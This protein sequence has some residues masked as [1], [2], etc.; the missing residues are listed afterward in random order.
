MDYVVVER[1]FP[2]RLTPEEVT[3]MAASMQ[4]LE[5]YRAKPVCS[6]LMPD[7][8]RL[9]CVFEAPDAEALRSLGRANGFPANAV[10]WSSTVHTP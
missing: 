5:L 10:I 8:R 9:V 3:A 7:G 4:C 6:Y 2:E 1:E